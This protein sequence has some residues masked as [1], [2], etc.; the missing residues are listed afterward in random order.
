[1]EIPSDEDVSELQ[2][3]LAE[4]A[5]EPQDDWKLWWERLDALRQDL[6]AQLEES[7]KAEAEAEERGADAHAEQAAE[8]GGRGAAAAAAADQRALAGAK[9]E[10]LQQ[11]L[12]AVMQRHRLVILLL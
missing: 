6:E 10:Q 9:T 7:L 2:R 5:T 12:Q 4:V 8:G 1:M 11:K 3:I